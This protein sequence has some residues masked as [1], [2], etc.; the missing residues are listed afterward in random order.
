MFYAHF[1]QMAQKTK[2][3]YEY[4]VIN[5]I[6]RERLEEKLAYYKPHKSGSF[7]FPCHKSCHILVV[8]LAVIKL[9]IDLIHCRKCPL[10]SI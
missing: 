2:T 9:L 3:P 4:G 8:S 5:T 7:Q 6:A 10:L 1:C